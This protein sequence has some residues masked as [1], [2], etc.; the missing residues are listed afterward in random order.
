MVERLHIWITGAS[1]GIGAAIAQQLAPA[2]NIT[3]SGRNEASLLQ[4]ENMLPGG[5]A[6]VVPCDVADPVSVR[7]AYQEAS[8]LFGPVD[9]LIANA[10]I[11]IF[12]PLDEMSEQEFDDLIDINLR[13]VFYSTKAVLPSMIERRRGMIVDINSV[14][15]LRAFPG[16]GAYAASKAGVAAMM[17]ALRQEVR[18]SGIKVTSVMIGATETDIWPDEARLEHAQRM[19]KAHDV[20]VAIEG[21]VNTFHNPRM[22][23]EEVVVRPQN[24]DL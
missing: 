15:T 11:G 5:C 2:H 12:K 10:G 20:A 23:L 18:A 22:H 24:G 1:R 16:N 4:I 6:A 7:D 8:A 17:R 3:L 21:V 19:M 13:G 9:V 14:S